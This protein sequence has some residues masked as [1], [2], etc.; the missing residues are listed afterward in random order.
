MKTKK[1]LRRKIPQMKFPKNSINIQ[2]GTTIVVTK[3]NSSPQR[4][5]IAKV[6]L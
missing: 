2:C 6:P 4:V 3:I 5:R 1:V